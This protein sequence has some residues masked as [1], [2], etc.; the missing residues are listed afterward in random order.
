MLNL[1]SY[2]TLGICKKNKIENSYEFMSSGLNHGSYQVSYDGYTWSDTDSS[3]N[4]QYSGWYYNQGDTVTVE[5]IPKTKKLKFTR[6]LDSPSSSS[7]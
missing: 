7:Y 6:N 4:E 1:S 2:V 3:I 5:F